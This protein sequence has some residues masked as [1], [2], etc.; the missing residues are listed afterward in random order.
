MLKLDFDK[1]E[2]ANKSDQQSVTSHS[3]QKA[4]ELLMQQA[5]SLGYYEV[6]CLFTEDGLPLAHIGVDSD[7]N[8]EILAE[9]SIQLQE[10]RKSVHQYNA[11]VG[12]NEIVFESSNYRKLVFRIIKA[13]GHN[14][15]LAIAVPPNRSYRAFTNKLIKIIKKTSM[16]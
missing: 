8:E 16:D 12:L 14:V 1:I 7:D 3:P 11:F 5:V 13:F 4:I 6:V 10:I 15:V 2:K 9:I